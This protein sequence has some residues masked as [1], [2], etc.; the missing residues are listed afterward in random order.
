L[1]QPI[2]GKRKDNATAS[3]TLAKLRRR[4]GTD[5]ETAGLNRPSYEVIAL[6][7]S[8]GLN[9]YAGFRPA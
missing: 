2:N 6:L 9:G 3:M 7:F 1:V 5:R 4:E 8:C